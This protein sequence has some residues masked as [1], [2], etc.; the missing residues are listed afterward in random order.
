MFAWF[1]LTHHQHLAT[2]QLHTHI[3]HF[4]QWHILNQF[5]IPQTV[6]DIKQMSSYWGYIFLLYKTLFHCKCFQFPITATVNSYV[7]VI[8]WICEKGGKFKSSCAVTA[9]WEKS[10]QHGSFQNYYLPPRLFTFTHE[11][12]LL[13]KGLKAIMQ[14]GSVAVVIVAVVT[15]I[16]CVIKRFHVIIWISYDRNLVG[17]LK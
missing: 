7:P 1:F 17:G 10:S 5:L 12:H 11:S 4:H 8:R 15:T 3:H 6:S 16:F 2:P 9:H 13:M 14:R